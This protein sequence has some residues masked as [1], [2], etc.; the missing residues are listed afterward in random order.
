MAEIDVPRILQI[1]VKNSAADVFMYTGAKISMKTP[2]GFAQLG[3]LLVKLGVLGGPLLLVLRLKD[4]ELG[5][6]D[7]ACGLRA[8]APRAGE[9]QRRHERSR[10]CLEHGQTSS[11]FRIS[12]V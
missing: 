4:V 12:V 2:K 10:D 8:P 6:V 7:E 11:R 3:E 5:I 9:H 1:M